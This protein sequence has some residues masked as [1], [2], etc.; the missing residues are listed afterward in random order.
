[1]SSKGIYAARPCPCGHK[2]CR[3]WHVSPVADIQGVQ[4]YRGTGPR[5][6]GP[7]EP[8]G[9]AG[10]RGST[11]TEMRRLIREYGANA[12]RQIL[13]FRKELREGAYD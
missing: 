6:S 1:M 4:L 13:L 2:N 11:I 12:A 8:N 3:A 10:M 5:S 9:E 7:P